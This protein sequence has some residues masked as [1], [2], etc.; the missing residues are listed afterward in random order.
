M[1]TKKVLILSFAIL[2]LFPLAGDENE[3]ALFNQRV[4]ESERE[5]FHG[6]C[7]PP[8]YNLSATP[9]P[10]VSTSASFIYWRAVQDGMDIA[11]SQSLTL[12]ATFSRNNGSDVLFAKTEYQPGFKV[13]IGGNV[14]LDG[15]TLWSEYTWLHSRTVTAKTASPLEAFPNTVGVWNNDWFP[16][17]NNVHSLSTYFR[18]AYKID[19]ADLVLSRPYYMGTKV[20]LKPFAG[21][22]GAWIAQK[23]RSTEERIIY[24]TGISN[25]SGSSRVTSHCWGVGPRVGVDGN[26]FLGRGAHFIGNANASLLYTRYTK[27]TCAVDNVDFVSTPTATTYGVQFSEAGYNTVRPNAGLGLGL[28]WSGYLDSYFLDLSATYDFNVFWSQNMIRNLAKDVTAQGDL[29]LHGL[30]ANVRFDF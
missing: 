25:V 14:P 21:L 3:T 24:S 20:V 17:T 5:K 29:Y 15:W 6:I 12:P 27:I 11:V 2:Q 9:E 23:V 10:T 22:R 30:T 28:G 13:G 4:S 19:L 16:N 8:A 26:W 18:W 1:E 7:T